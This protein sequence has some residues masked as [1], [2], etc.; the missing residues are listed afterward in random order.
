[1]ARHIADFLFR[2]WLLSLTLHKAILW[3]ILLGLIVYG[4]TF[5]NGFVWD[6]YTNILFNPQVQS[7]NLFSIFE[8]SMIN[9]GLQYRPVVMLYFSLMYALFHEAAFFYH[10]INVALH[11]FNAVLVLHLLKRFFSLPLSL[12]LSL[13]FLVHPMQVESA[14]WI[15]TSGNLY[16]TFGLTALLLSI[17]KHVSIRTLL[18]V[19]VLLLLSLLTKE[20]GILFFFLI[21][22]YFMQQKKNQE[23]LLFSEFSALTIIMYA[24][25]RFSTGGNTLSEHGSIFPIAQLTFIER[26]M[27]IPS[28]IA[29]YF[30]TFVFPLKLVIMQHWVIRTVTFQN[31]YLPLTLILLTGVFCFALGVGLYRKHKEQFA[32]F[33][34]FLLWLLSGLLL[35]IQLFPLDMTV[36]DRWFY[37]PMVGLLGLFGI[38]LQKLQTQK[39]LHRVLLVIGCITLLLLSLRTVIR[40]T[41]WRDDLTLYTRDSRILNNFVIEN[42]LGW[43]YQNSKNFPEALRHYKKSVAMYPSWS[44]SLNN[45]AY[46]SAQ[47]GNIPEARMYAYRVLTAR[48]YSMQ[49]YHRDLAFTAW[50]LRRFDTPEAARDFSKKALQITPENGILW[51][52]LAITEAALG[53]RKA[54]LSAV[55]KA[56][57]LTQTP[58]MQ[59]LKTLIVSQQPIPPDI[60]IVN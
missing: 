23:A 19:S 5:L 54:A 38:A 43:N 20:T 14:T 8:Q 56:L 22:V 11:I 21:L 53:N 58:I 32:V 40:N 12:F 15:S 1:M 13:V 52:H 49:E 4:N 39:K 3:I 45:V 26:L 36:A 47:S 42:N 7:F 34:F 27:H 18:T 6:D 25:L 35:H 28:I 55:D 41:D 59:Q 50:I 9:L 37:F 29:Y 33:I 51:A 30:S 2:Q 16:F 44:I 24:I 31:F 60:A 48:N 57:Q 10:F 46:L 17:K